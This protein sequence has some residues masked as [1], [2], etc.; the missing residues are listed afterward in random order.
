MC[1]GK[2]AVKPSPLDKIFQLPVERSISVP[3]QVRIA[4]RLVKGVLQFHSTPWLQPYWRLQ[5]I[6]YFST[7]E[8]LA[9]SLDTLHIST[10]LSK[11]QQ[12]QQKQQDIVMLEN[13]ND[14]DTA[15]LACG[16]RN[17]T[18]HSLGVALL[19]VGQWSTINQDDVVEVRKIADLAERDSRLGPRYQAITRQCLDCDF[20]FGKDLSQPE[21]QAAIY[22]DVVCE[23]ESLI[24]TLEGK[25][26]S[27]KTG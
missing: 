4:L 23:L 10:E 12:Q 13:T 14:M 24:C 19:Q 2:K 17:L 25:P 26:Q 6:S 21:L 5:D 1:F 3:E 8:G 15:Q 27:I 22:K 11:Q 20:G 9:A 7:D 16:I 18:M